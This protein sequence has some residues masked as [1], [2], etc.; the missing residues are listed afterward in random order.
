MCSLSPLKIVKWSLKQTSATLLPEGLTTLHE[1]WRT[2]L[3]AK[4]GPI[5]TAPI[6]NAADVA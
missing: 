6:V 1:R 3:R 2:T 4:D 5:T